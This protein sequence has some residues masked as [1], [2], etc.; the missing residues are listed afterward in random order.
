MALKLLKVQVNLEV[1]ADQTDENDVRDA[2]YEAL[3]LQMENEDLVYTLGEDEE[4]AEDE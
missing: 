4:E 3:Q 2:V 1:K